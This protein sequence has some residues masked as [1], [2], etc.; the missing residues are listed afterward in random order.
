[1]ER[2]CYNKTM[3]REKIIELENFIFEH[4]TKAKIAASAMADFMGVVIG[5]KPSAITDFEIEK[6]ANVNPEEII[7][8]LS[9][10][11]LKALFFTHEYVSM[12]RPTLVEEAYVSRDFE[13]AAKLR[14]AF[15]K[16]RNSIDDL[17]Q[18]F[19]EKTWEESSREIGRLLG[20]PDTAIEYFIAEQDIDNAERQNLMDKYRFYAHSPEHHEQEYQDYDRKI[21]QALQDYAPKTAKIFS[22]NQRKKWL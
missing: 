1:M 6:I 14:E 5:V 9:R 16:M 10:V 13:T 17:G 21:Y 18:T 12:G 4:H 8:L 20:Y 11:G 3:D 2:L 7:E 15:Q 22:A 19:D